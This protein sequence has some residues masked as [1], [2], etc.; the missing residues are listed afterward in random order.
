MRSFWLRQIPAATLLLAISCG[1]SSTGPEENKSTPPDQEETDSVAPEFAGVTAAELLDDGQ[2]VLSWDSPGSDNETPRERLVYRAYASLD[3]AEIKFD[4]PVAISASGASELGVLGMPPTSEVSFVV[5]AVDEAG[6]EDDGTKSVKLTLPDARVPQFSGALE[7]AGVSRSE[8]EI[9]WEEGPADIDHYLVYHSPVP[10]IPF[11]GEP[12]EVKAGTTRLILDGLEEASDYHVTVRAVDADGRSDGNRRFIVG[13]TLDQT[14]PTFSGIEYAQAGGTNA[15]LS[16]SAAS[17]NVTLPGQLE[18]RIFVGPTAD[19][20]DFT[21]PL[22]TVIGD[23]TTVLSGLTPDT[24]YFFTLRAVDAQGNASTDETVLDTKTG[25]NAD[26]TAPVFAGITTLERVSSTSLRAT[27]AA[28]TDNLTPQAALVYDIYVSLEEPKPGVTP[29]S[30][31]TAPGV[32][33]FEIPALTPATFYYVAVRARDIA[34]LTDVNTKSLTTAT[35]SDDDAP[36]F[37]GITSIK[38]LSATSLQVSWAEANDASPSNSLVYDI[39]LATTAGGQNFSFPTR[40]VKGLTSATFTGL[41]RD[42]E[43]FAVVYVSDPDDN[44][45]DTAKEASGST[46][47]DTTGPDLPSK[48][49]ASATSETSLNVS[50]VPAEDDSYD[51][52]E[53][54]YLVQYRRKGTTT[55]LSAGALVAPP[56]LSRSITGL[57]VETTYEVR[58]LPRDGEPNVGNPSPIAEVT[59]SSDATPPS[60]PTGLALNATTIYSGGY[61]NSVTV[62]WAASS[63]NITASSNLTYEICYSTLSTGCNSFST[64]ASTSAGQTSTTIFNLPWGTKYYF[65]VRA[66]DDAGNGA[67]SAVITDNGVP[68]NAVAPAL[69]EWGSS[70]RV[71]P[72]N[73]SDAVFTN[74]RYQ[75]DYLAYSINPSTNTSCTS[76]YV[77]GTTTGPIASEGWSRGDWSRDVTRNF[78][79]N[80]VRVT[81]IDGFNNKSLIYSGYFYSNDAADAQAILEPLFNLNCTNQYCHDGVSYA[82]W[83]ITTA[84]QNPS[85]VYSSLGPVVVPYSLSSRLFTRSADPGSSGMP[86]GADPVDGIVCNLRTWILAG[87]PN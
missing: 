8:L 68:S 20:I 13:S 11:L 59:T 10:E 30:F 14:P 85:P 27:W 74:L 69:A 19:A 12:I 6:N 21:T 86:L 65:R 34:G 5:R 76:A 72:A 31:T 60:A 75:I 54:R 39:F 55:W 2:V 56:T 66:V 47:P 33:S 48:P 38:G 17:D 57:S 61:K 44:V 22:K 50:W 46:L 51:Q 40:S 53:L 15:R 58:I 36:T 26:E 73:A 29:A 25:P 71:Y 24:E 63:D 67:V 77:T 83:T 18:Y 4:E 49:Q 87:A 7:A 45:N 64:L 43:Y 84:L 80:R 32:T 37:V 62:S 1:D 28:G 3:G 78:G 23:T 70:L 42:R 52:S 82:R 35:K 81:A 9:S 79:T 41:S 16:W